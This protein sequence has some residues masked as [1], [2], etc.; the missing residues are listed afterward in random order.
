MTEHLG[1][2]QRFGEGRAVDGDERPAAASAVVMDELRDL[3]FSRTALARDEDG[4]IRRR[5]A[6]SELDRPAERQGGAQHRDLFAMT[7]L[8][9]EF[10]LE[11]AGL[12]RD[13]H[14]VGSPPDQ[15]LQV[16]GGK[17]LRQVVPSPR[18]QRLDA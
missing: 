15:D 14:G 12:A 2:E 13:H 16:S 1:L 5:Y 10:V 11:R 9:L 4:C 18:A 6:A 8:A 7:V 3:F 17:W